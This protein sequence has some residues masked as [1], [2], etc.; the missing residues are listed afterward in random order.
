M[1]YKGSDSH[2][3]AV[4]GD[5]VGDPFKD[6]SGPSMNIL[7]KL[8]CLIGLVLAPILGGHGSETALHETNS[9]EMMFISEDGTKTILTDKSAKE[10]SKEIKVEMTEEE[11][12]TVA[13]VT[14]TTIENG[15]ESVETK[16]F[17]GTE[18]EV[19]ALIDALKDVE[20]NIDKKVIKEVVEEVEETN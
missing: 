16:T 2:K 13:I 8:T 18:E 5:T 10:V 17:K 7:I 12:Q 20:V 1:T 19:K 15:E 9:E 6:T 3:A 14:T 4:T 11:G